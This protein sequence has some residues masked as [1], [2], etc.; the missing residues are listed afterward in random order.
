LYNQERANKSI[1]FAEVCYFFNLPVLGQLEFPKVALV[2]L[3]SEPDPAMLRKLHNTYRLCQAGTDADLTVLPARDLDSVVAM[4]PNP[5][6]GPR[7]FGAT[8]KPGCRAYHTGVGRKRDENHP[9]D[10]MYV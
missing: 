9:D 5:R 1:R 8:Q 10:P 3:F 4:L 7:A 6:R 2:K